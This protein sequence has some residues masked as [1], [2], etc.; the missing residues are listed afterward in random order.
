MWMVYIPASNPFKK[1]GKF[2]YLSKFIVWRFFKESFNTKN[3]LTKIFET[4]FFADLRLVIPYL[5]RRSRDTKQPKIYFCLTHHYVH[6]WQ[7]LSSF[8]LTYI[9]FLKVIFC[10]FWKPQKAF[11]VLLP[12]W[13]FAITLGMMPTADALQVSLSTLRLSKKLFCNPSK[14]LTCF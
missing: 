4:T 14:D 6:L 2:K 7:S 3:S 10:S 11:F 1:C 9:V 12:L 5:E 13:N 8:I